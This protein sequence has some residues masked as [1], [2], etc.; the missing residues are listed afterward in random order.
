MF[1]NVRLNKDRRRRRINAG[2]EVNPSEIERLLPEAF[3]F[4]WQRYRVKIDDAVKRFVFALQR[5]PIFESTKIIADMKFTGRLGTAE[6]ALFHT[7]EPRGNEQVLHE[8]K[9]RPNDNPD[10]AP[11]D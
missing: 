2:R 6:N 5:H 10:N 9:D 8:S 4:L 3:R 7:L 11:I 1:G